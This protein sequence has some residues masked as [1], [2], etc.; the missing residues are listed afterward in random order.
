ME[1]DLGGPPDAALYVHHVENAIDIP[2]DRFVTLDGVRFHYLDW[3]GD[4]SPMLLLAGMGCTAHVFAELAPHLTDRFRVVALSRRG[5]GLTD[6]VRSG[7]ELTDAAEDARGLLDSLEIERAHLVGHSMG[8]GEVSVLAARHPDRVASVIYLDGAYDWADSPHGE[9][10]PG[11]AA[12][13][14]RFGSYEDFA[15]FVRSIGPEFEVLWGPAF[16]AM[17]RTLVD[18]HPD[19]TVTEKLPDA[20][21]APF[22]HALQTFR[23]PYSEITAP[24]LAIY[25]VGDSLQGAAATWRAECRQRFRAETASGQVL[26]I[27]D[28]THYL[29]ID[30]RDDVLLAMCRFLP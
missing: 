26:E 10:E 29:F 11:E 1:L 30:H 5:H 15:A 12:S 18:I 23:H 19:G 7:Y 16:D 25:A 4:G 27:R 20:E 6:Q 17:C 13:P 2:P 24:A 14:D 9:E 3:G 8:G 21:A 28:A 22:V